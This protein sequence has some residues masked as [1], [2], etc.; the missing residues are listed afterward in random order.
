MDDELNGR[1]VII[2]DDE[3]D[4]HR[5][6]DRLATAI[7]ES[8]ADLY[9]H[10]ERLVWLKDGAFIHAARDVLAELV[11]TF[12]V[13]K[14]VRNVGTSDEPV[15]ERRY[16]S[17]EPNETMLRGLLKDGNLLGRVSKLGASA[18]PEMPRSY[19]LELAGHF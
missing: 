11:R 1:K 2:W 10:N 15:Y 12:V 16:V 3:G 19:R 9:N 13:V 7:T 6:I 5:N 18:A 4:P 8:A 14:T 17:F